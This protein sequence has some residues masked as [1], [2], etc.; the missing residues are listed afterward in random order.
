MAEGC[1]PL[2]QL[3]DRAVDGGQVLCRAARQ[4]PV[5]FSEWSRGRQLSGALDR[6]ALQLATEVALELAD[7]VRI[8]DR[9]VVAVPPAACLEVKRPA[10][11]LDVD[12]DHAGT[13]PLAAEGRHRE[14]GEVAH[15]AVVALED[16]PPDRLAELVQVDSVAGS[17]EALILDSALE[18]LRLG[19][20]EEVAVE[21]QLE[22][23]PVLL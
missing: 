9:A 22:D 10:D 5:Q 18:R 4:G 7:V 16:R 2:L 1:D 15:L 23:S 6:G 3:G 12:A 11:S 13:L 17:L 21:E 14:P 19:R 20:S 8:E